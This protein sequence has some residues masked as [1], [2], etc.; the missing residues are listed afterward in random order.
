[1]HLL[2]SELL[3][4]LLQDQTST[5]LIKA[6]NE[7]LGKLQS[8]SIEGAKIVLL[9]DILDKLLNKCLFW[10]GQVED[11]FSARIKDKYTSMVSKI[12]TLG[13]IDILEAL[14]THS[15]KRVYDVAVKILSEHYQ[16]QE[17]E[18]EKE[19]FDEYGEDELMEN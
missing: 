10:S 2:D 15:T 19:Q 1:M 8:N 9:L 18:G 3:H 17:E 11:P 16:D 4:S 13:L 6:L 14:Q 5:H 12:E 7:L